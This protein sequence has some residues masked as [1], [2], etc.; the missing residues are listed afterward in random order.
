MGG[1]GPSRTSF[2]GRRGPG[3]SRTKSTEPSPAGLG[4]MARLPLASH[5]PTSPAPAFSST[6]IH[7]N[8]RGRLRQR[9]GPAENRKMGNR[10]GSELRGK[11][12]MG[13]A[14]RRRD[15]GDWVVGAD[16]GIGSPHPGL[17]PGSHCPC[18]CFLTLKPGWSPQVSLHGSGVC[19]CLIRGLV[20][21][22]GTWSGYPSST[23]NFPGE[24]TFYHKH[25]SHL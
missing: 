5:P 9:E 15:R 23:T 22:T 18:P 14:E 10:W 25:L 17:C 6:F 3:E 21:T 1:E 16:R 7:R 20:R 11:G 19:T 2:R 4:Q 13:G 12:T 24:P 8:L